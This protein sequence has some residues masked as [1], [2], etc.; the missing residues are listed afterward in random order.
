MWIF[1]IQK[2][3]LAYLRHVSFENRTRTVYSS[4]LPH[5]MQ[6]VKT[7]FASGCCDAKLLTGPTAP[8]PG[9]TFPSVVATPPIDVIISCPV[10]ETAITDS[11]K[12]MK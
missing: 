11:I 7:H 9:P 8:N 10:A 2:H 12:M 6:N 4:S 1:V 5:S 3:L